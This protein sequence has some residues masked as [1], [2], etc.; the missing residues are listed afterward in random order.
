MQ[1][2]IFLDVDGPLIPSPLYF[3]SILVS[4]D[5]SYF[6]TVAVA[7]IN[8]L[9]MQTKAKIVFNSTHN[10]H[11]YF[12]NFDGKWR[13]L[14]MD[15]IRHG[16]KPEYI[17]DMWKTGYPNIVPEDKFYAPKHERLRAIE[18]WQAVNEQVD[19]I[20]FDDE[21]FTKDPR[22]I[23]VDFDRGIDYDSYKSACAQFGVNDAMKGLLL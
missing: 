10:S 14:K 5:R 8:K 18:H 12:D 2:I 9:C 7:F 11:E 4:Q 1:K 23:V 22:L 6:S 13:S 3:L 19:W 21:P 16:I 20:A 17:H 15:A